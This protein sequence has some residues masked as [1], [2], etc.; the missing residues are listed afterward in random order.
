MVIDDLL[1]NKRYFLAEFLQKMFIVPPDEYI[2]NLWYLFF[3]TVKQ[4]LIGI[5]PALKNI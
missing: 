1:G 5:L 2:I 4:L 3:A